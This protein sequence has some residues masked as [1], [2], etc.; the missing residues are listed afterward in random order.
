MPKRTSKR[1]AS[2]W[3]TNSGSIRAQQWGY[4]DPMDEQDQSALSIELIDE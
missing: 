1:S 2:K 3:K 4:P